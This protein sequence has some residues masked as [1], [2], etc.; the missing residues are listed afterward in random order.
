MSAP[1]A[2]SGRQ[3]SPQW[4]QLLGQ[5]SSDQAMV[6]QTLADLH[7]KVPGYEN[8][9]RPSLEASVRR[10]IALTVRTIRDGHE[11]APDEVA[12]AD[13]LAVER[14]AQGVPIGSVL[15]GFRVS[16]S[17]IFR[18]ILTRAPEWGIPTEQ[19]LTSSTL[20]WALGDA[21]STRAVAVYQEKEVS[22]AVTDSALR[23]EW[24]RNVVTSAMPPAERIRGATLYDVPTTEPLRAM[25][26]SAPPGSE[27]DRMQRVESW[28]QGAEIRVLVAVQGSCLVGIM[29]NR[30]EPGAGPQGLTIGLGE[31]TPL[32]ELPRSFQSASMTL[33]AAEGI[34]R[35]GVVDLAR[36]SWRLGVHNCPETTELLY[37]LHLAPLENSGEFGQHILE[38]VDA[39]LK[40]RM[41]IP[42]AARSIP[43]HVN[44][45]RYRLQRF[46]E[47]TGADLGD[48]NTLIELSWVL[49]AGKHRDLNRRP[50]S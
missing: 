22:R 24:I 34:G 28:A 45:L 5:M 7:K 20:L 2:H 32:E 9:P 30:P 27:V 4:E 47:L 14:Y 23:A 10:N 40:H 29:V 50:S 11:P 41:S 12:E 18:N 26:L 1:T 31:A 17:M 42:L 38:A 37:G 3:Q 8:V 13:A 15:A 16:L 21:F 36:L 46:S 25:V 19:I 39:Y 49:A 48:L 6:D 33:E 44:T 43:I 35:T